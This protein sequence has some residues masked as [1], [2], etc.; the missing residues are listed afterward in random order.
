MLQ[1]E[2]IYIMGY[3]GHAYVVIDAALYN[4]YKIGGYFERERAIEDPYGLLFLGD[5]KEVD[6]TKIVKDGFIF[7]AIGD[8]NIRKK[9][10]QFVQLKGLKQLSLISEGVLISKLS[11]IGESTFVGPNAVINSLAS[12]GVGCIVNTGAIIEHECV[13]GNF[14]HI[15]PGTVLLGNVKVGENTFIGSNAVIKQ[16]V[17]VGDNVIIGAGSVVLTDI[18]SNSIWV[19]NPAKKLFKK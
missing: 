4:G 1:S 10:I 16:G 17:T 2:N 3:S 15:A 12:I 18:P 7:P 8:N 6:A 5:E 11:K 13:I 9:V 19:G 14:T